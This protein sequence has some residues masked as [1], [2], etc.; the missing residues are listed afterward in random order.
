MFLA[1]RCSDPSLSGAVGAAGAG[2]GAIGLEVRL[3]RV[4]AVG[5]QQVP[6][7]AVPLADSPA[8]DARAPV[9]ELLA[10][11]LAA[12]PVRLLEWD[13]LAAREVEPV[14]VVRVVAIEAPAMLLVVPAGRCRSCI[15]GERRRVRLTGRLGVARGAGKIPSV[16]G[17]GGTSGAL[18]SCAPVP[19]AGR[20]GR[21]RPAGPGRG[22]DGNAHA[23][24]RGPTRRSGHDVPGSGDS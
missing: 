3:V 13:P 20:H 9:A 4:V 16:N 2:F 18:A 1:H 22:I 6:L 8:V 5:A 17:G 15:V 10:V 11:A 24:R 12:E 7:V 14:A 23:P 21:R 19:G